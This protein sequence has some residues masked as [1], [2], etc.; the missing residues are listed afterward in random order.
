MYKIYNREYNKKRRNILGYIEYIVMNRYIIQ[1][2]YIYY[3]KTGGQ[4][5]DCFEKR[6]VERIFLRGGVGFR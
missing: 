1:K 6:I 2:C 3:K 5:M 4:I